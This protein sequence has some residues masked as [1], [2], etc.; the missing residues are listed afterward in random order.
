MGVLHGM[1]SAGYTGTMDAC[2]LRS[3]AA[4]GRHLR[5]VRFGDRLH[6]N[7]LLQFRLG[8]WVRLGGSRRFHRHRVC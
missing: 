3:N 8:V 2:P 1:G 5:L 4:L 7:L 6:E